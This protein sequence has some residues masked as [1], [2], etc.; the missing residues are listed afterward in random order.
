MSFPNT[1]PSALSYQNNLVFNQLLTQMNPGIV[2]ELTNRRSV[3]NFFLRLMNKKFG[4]STPFYAADG[5]IISASR[6]LDVIQARVQTRTAPAAN[7]I[8]LTFDQPVDAARVND[9][10]IYGNAYE[11]AGRVINVVNGAGG[12]IE[13]VPLYDFTFGVSDFAAGAL[14]LIYGD[15]SVNFVSGQKARRFLNPTLDFNYT[16]TVREGMWVARREKGSTRVTTNGSQPTV[17]EQNGFWYTSFQLDALRR[18]E[19]SLDI[20]RRF[21]ERGKTSYSDGERTTNGGFRWAV[22]NRGGDY[23][24]FSTPLTETAWNN[25]VGSV[26]DKVIGTSTPL[27]LFAGRGLWATI[28]SFYAQTIT[29]TGILN[30]FAGEDVKGFNIPTYYIPGIAKQVAYIE[31]PILNDPRVFGDQCTIPGYTQFTKAQMTGMLMSDDMLESVG[32]GMQP[33]FRQWHWGQQE[34]LIGE[35]K[36]LDQGNGGSLTPDAD[37]I[38]RANPLSLA[39][40]DD[41]TSVGVLTD[42]GIDGYGYG[43]GWIEPLV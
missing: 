1:N 30:T 35:L 21:S 3:Y 38:I 24:G 15:N 43:C 6:G 40:L 4:G 20:D 36:G 7:T 13:I 27:L 37:P 39:T 5:K 8:R 25:L 23:L 28:N 2:L 32:A 26:Y 18:L 42:T 33:M 9:K 17:F 16:S 19:M 10:V 41:A 31:D 29:Q 11:R 34:F 22:K 14:L 12:Y